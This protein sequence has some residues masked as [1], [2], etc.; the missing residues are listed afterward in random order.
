MEQSAN[1]DF[2]WTRWTGRTSSD[3]TGPDGAK[4]GKY[5]LYIETSSPRKQD[6]RAV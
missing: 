1:D 5:Y 6:D 4:E 2:D 3:D